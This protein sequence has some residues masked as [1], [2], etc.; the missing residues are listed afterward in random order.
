MVASGNLFSVFTD[1]FSELRIGMR[2]PRTQTLYLSPDYL[3]QLPR[4]PVNIL[5]DDAS[6]DVCQG[7]HLADWLIHHHNTLPMSAYLAKPDSSSPSM[8]EVLAAVIYEALQHRLLTSEL[9]HPPDT[10][11]PSDVAAELP[12]VPEHENGNS[13]YC[14]FESDMRRLQNAFQEQELNMQD[15]SWRM[16]AEECGDDLDALVGQ[17]RDDT[18]RT[19]DRF[20]RLYYDVVSKYGKPKERS[21]SG[22]DAP[23]GNNGSWGS[24]GPPSG[25]SPG[26]PGSCSSRPQEKSSL[27]DGHRRQDD[28]TH[29]TPVSK[30]NSGTTREY[31]GSALSRNL[32]VLV[33]DDIPFAIGQSTEVRL[34]KMPCIRIIPESLYLYS[35]LA[36]YVKWPA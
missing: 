8:F 24:D 1:W 21:G 20:L 26:D 32:S 22:C 28:T 34:L 36:D 33:P 10:S 29:D 13:L 18:I 14:S 27:D 7:K 2:D 19:R 4:L 30:E 12:E 31:G 9:R 35:A 3:S 15:A 17:R 23:Q 6:I 16:A 11:S 5:T 25:G